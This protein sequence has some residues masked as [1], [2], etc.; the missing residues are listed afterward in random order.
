MAHQLF[1][2]GIVVHSFPDLKKVKS[3]YDN[4]FISV[5]IGQ[6]YQNILIKK[7]IC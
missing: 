5:L 2:I 4:F 1:F 7:A 6:M 3:S